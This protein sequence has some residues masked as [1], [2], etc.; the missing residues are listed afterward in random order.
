MD[1]SYGKTPEHKG[2][3]KHKRKIATAPP[4]VPHSSHISGP[5]PPKTLPPHYSARHPHG[6]SPAECAGCEGPIQPRPY[7]PPGC[8]GV[9]NAPHVVHCRPDNVG[10]SVSLPPAPALSAR[11][12]TPDDPGPSAR[13]R[14][15]L[16]PVTIAHLHQTP[17]T[18]G[19]SHRLVP[20]ARRTR[21]D[22]Q[23]AGQQ[24]RP[25][26]HAEMWRAIKYADAHVPP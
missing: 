19:G 24:G 22:V 18:G 20:L 1:D 6:R 14:Q 16:P 26:A 5:P 21:W 15:T 4:P 11:A 3:D 23:D 2:E 25:A 12:A 10:T 7:H 8:S 13:R 17:P 9:Q